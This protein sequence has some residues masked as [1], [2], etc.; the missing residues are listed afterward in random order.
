MYVNLNALITSVL[1]AVKVSAN[2]MYDNAGATLTLNND[3]L[4]I[5]VISYQPTL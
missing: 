3:K 2:S 4:P 1:V 5:P